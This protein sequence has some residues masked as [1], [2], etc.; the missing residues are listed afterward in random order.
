MEP[1][2]VKKPYMIEHVVHHN[3]DGPNSARRSFHSSQDKDDFNLFNMDR[4]WEHGLGI[5][6]ILYFAFSIKYGFIDF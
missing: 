3:S 4:N 1:N 2:R 5:I 6:L